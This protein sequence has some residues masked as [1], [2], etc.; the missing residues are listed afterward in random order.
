MERIELEFKK[1][2]LEIV[3]DLNFNDKF[4]MENSNENSE[5]NILKKQDIINLKIKDYFLKNLIFSDYTLIKSCDINDLEYNLKF[6]N[7][8]LCSN[9]KIAKFQIL[10]N[11]IIKENKVLIS[12][13]ISINKMNPFKNGEFLFNL[14][15]DLYNK[16]VNLKKNIYSN[17]LF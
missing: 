6:S 2:E 9:W 8:F 15:D 5:T 1:K 13:K 11:D 12:K 7:D 16:L 4:E 14:S 3:N 17:F 10:E